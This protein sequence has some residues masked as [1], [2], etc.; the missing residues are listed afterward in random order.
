VLDAVPREDLEMAV[1]HRHRQR[2]DE[3]ALRL[4]KEAMHP[5]VQVERLRRAIQLS[6]RGL[7]KV[8]PGVA[9]AR[10][11][12]YRHARTFSTMMVGSS[13]T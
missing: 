13:G 11:P 9:Q 2:D 8:T 10:H 7:E 1:I 3:R 5:R 4:L 12:E 6:E